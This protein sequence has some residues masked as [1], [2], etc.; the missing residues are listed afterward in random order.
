MTTCLRKSTR[1]TKW[2]V[3]R[4]NKPIPITPAHRAVFAKRTLTLKLSMEINFAIV[5][6]LGLSRDQKLEIQKTHVFF[7]NGKHQSNIPFSG[8]K[9]LHTFR[10]VKGFRKHKIYVKK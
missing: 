10:S 8:G 9:F 7:K 3:S 4:T 2:T 1:T 5:I 6:D